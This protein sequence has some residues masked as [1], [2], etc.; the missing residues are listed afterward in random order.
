MKLHRDSLS[1]LYY[2]AL[3]AAEKNGHFRRLIPVEEV[4]EDTPFYMN[5]PGH[6]QWIVGKGPVKRDTE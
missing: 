3:E 5:H 6:P 4:G 1:F 2:P